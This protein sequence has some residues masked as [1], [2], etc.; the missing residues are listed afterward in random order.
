MTPMMRL[1]SCDDCSMPFIAAMAFCTTSPDCPAS[2]LATSTDFA[3]TLAFSAL[4]LTCE[5]SSS[6]AAAV[7]S[8]L[9]ACC[10]V[11]CDR[12]LAALLISLVPLPM[13]TTEWL[14]VRIVASRLSIVAL[15]S[16]FS[17]AY[18]PGNSSVM[19]K[20]RSP[21]ERCDRPLP[22]RATMSR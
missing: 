6:R 17:W 2:L 1:T 16:R 22:R 19:R 20:A 18:S 3:A 14:T 13:L 11:R 7:S 8:R 12:S 21:E 15:K 10:S 4:A 9:A 5:V